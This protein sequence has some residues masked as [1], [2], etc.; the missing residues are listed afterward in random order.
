MQLRARTGIS[1]NKS[2]AQNTKRQIILPTLARAEK[3]FGEKKI[4]A[5]GAVA[6]GISLRFIIEANSPQ[7]TD[8]LISRLPLWPLA[9]SRVTPLI[10]R[11]ASDEMVSNCCWKI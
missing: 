5:G 6:G 2:I 3:L 11:L 1:R 8:K 7:E 10:A 9:E 4:V